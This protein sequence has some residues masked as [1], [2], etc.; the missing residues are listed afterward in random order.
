MANSLDGLAKNALGLG[1][2]G[3]AKRLFQASLT[4]GRE[5]S[6]PRHMARA[7]AGLADV[8]NTLG[9]HGEA[10]QLAQESLVLSEEFDAESLVGEH[11]RTLGD[12]ACGLGDFHEGK[13]YCY[14]A[15]EM[16]MAI[17]DAFLAP[18]VLV[19]IASLLASEGRK[20]SAL[21]LLALVL[22]HPASSSRPETRLTP[23]L[24]SWLLSCR[25][26][27]WQRPRSAVGLGTWKRLSPSCWSLDEMTWSV[28]TGARWPQL[29]ILAGSKSPLLV[30][31]EAQGEQAEHNA[32]LFFVFLIG[33]G[34]FCA[35][36]GPR[37]HAMSPPL[38]D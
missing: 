6:H 17:P 19:G 4:I 14:R 7:L 24:P 3:E 2:H 34:D 22:H 27:P 26:R 36:K 23:L 16:A 1:E 12:A 29:G 31:P 18:P 8:A 38:R 33:L 15:L 37:T 30:I 20:E 35:P 5:M 11:L 32:R 9:D 13:E 25:P 28:R 21:E 10:I